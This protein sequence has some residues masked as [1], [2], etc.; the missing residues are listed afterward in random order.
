MKLIKKAIFITLAATVAISLSGC[1]DFIYLHNEDASSTTE[2][3][4]PYNENAIKISKSVV[5]Y[6]GYVEPEDAANQ[7]YLVAETHTIDYSSTRDYEAQLLKELVNGPDQK[8]N[9]LTSL[10]PEG[11]TFVVNAKDKDRFISVTVSKNFLNPPD[12][13][14]TD[15]TT[16]TNYVNKYNMLK[17][18]AIYSIVD[19]LT[20][21]GKYD[22]V[23]ILTDIDGDGV[24]NIPLRKDV[25]FLDANQ[26]EFL[27]T[28]YRN[29]K[30]ILTPENSLTSM[31]YYLKNKYFE[32]LYDLI[33]LV[34]LNGDKKPTQEE[35]TN[36]IEDLNFTIGSYSVSNAIV[37]PD[38]TTATMI[39]N[40]QVNVGTG[41]NLETKNLRNYTVRLIKE[42]GLWKIQYDDLI[43]ILTN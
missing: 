20:E 35:I 15:W 7:E 40:T 6:Y 13:F 29:V 9:K 38:G 36:T 11:T 30:V 23:Q 8:G 17:R 39:L 22:S 27:D 41:K 43:N 31:M 16:R 10:I 24:G 26:N 3:I 4:A 18:L 14:P 5:C 37:S 19:T 12:N 28:M 34:D 25:G 32:N 33:M 2:P 1:Y 21:S 42:D